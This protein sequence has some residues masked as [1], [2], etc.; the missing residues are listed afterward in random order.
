[1]NKKGF[2]LVELFVV[3]AIIGILLS[4]L[5]PICQ[6]ATQKPEVVD[7]VIV[8]TQL[9]VPTYQD[10]LSEPIRYVE[11]QDGRLLKCWSDRVP[12]IL[13]K[14]VRITIRA[15]MVWDCVSMEGEKY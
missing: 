4:L 1:M 13:Q 14:P 6:V 2:T 5:I 9:Y 10:N 12:I 11:L 7:T 8:N 15:N 3:I